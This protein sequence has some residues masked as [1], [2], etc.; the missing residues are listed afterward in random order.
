M[1]ATNHEVYLG[2]VR[3]RISLSLMIIVFLFCGHQLY[4]QDWHEQNDYKLNY[5]LSG[6][7]ILII[8]DDEATYEELVDVAD[9]WKS[10][11]AVV[12]VAAPAAQ[13]NATKMTYS[14]NSASGIDHGGRLTLNSDLL[15]TDVNADDF[16]AVYLPGGDSYANLTTRHKET[17]AKILN[18]ANAQGKV[19]GALCHGPA[20]LS[21]TDFVKGKKV[22]VE[23]GTAYK[24]LADAGAVY[25]DIPLVIDKNVITC[26]FPYVESMIYALAEKLQYPKGGGPLEKIDKAKT[27]FEKGLENLSGGYTYKNLPVNRDTIK[28]IIRLGLKN[29]IS[30][31]YSY[32]SKVRFVCVDDK[33]KIEK[34]KGL[35]F[36][37][38]KADY[39]QISEDMFRYLIGRAL[40]APVL[41]FAYNDVGAINSIDNDINRKYEES[42]LISYNGSSCQNIILSATNLG[43]SA[44]LVGT[45]FFRIMEDEL[46]ELLNL[47]QNVDLVNVLNIGYPELKLPPT[48]TR[49]VSEFLF[50]NQF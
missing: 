26:R 25:Q 10:F 37:K 31:K 49:P 8:G 36:E 11:G 1:N 21:I 46:T 28:T 7:K 18:K 13:F 16:T 23:G 44:N 32:N 27:P 30:E 17:I 20:I 45:T 14:S 47:P 5:D 33:D 2:R 50:F 34:L 29:I 19:I 35:V 22:T 42:K 9:V 15:I 4:A 38:N 41:L 43:L 24:L 39:N 40:N 3:S 48:T 12:K 6:Q